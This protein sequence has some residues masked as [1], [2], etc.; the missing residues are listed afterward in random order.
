VLIHNILGLEESDNVYFVEESYASLKNNNLSLQY[1]ENIRKDP[2][3]EV[4]GIKNENG[5]IIG[6]ILLS[7]ETED[8]QEFHA[9]FTNLVSTRPVPNQ[10]C[11]VFSSIAQS[12]KL[13]KLQNTTSRE[14]SEAVIEYYSLSLVNRKVCENCH[15]KKEPYKMVYIESRNDKLNGILKRYKLK[16]EILEICCGNGMS[17]LPL[18]KMGY[19]PLAI[20]YD[21][22]QICQ[23]LEHNVLD[24]KRTIVLDATRLSEFFPENSFDTIVGFMLGTIYSFNKNIWEKIMG[25]AAWLLKSEGMIILTVNQKEEIEILK[26]ALEKA[27][28]SGN[29]IDNTDDKGIYD[30]W[31]YV[32]TK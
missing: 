2:E 32:G 12:L 13:K 6:L 19:R 9:I 21:R 17:T 22:C 26:S 20:D 15:I 18:H 27:H 3:A 23:G 8:S 30:Q 10:T 14:F 29:L 25:E 4:S 24:P 28:V 1:L 31:V 7:P 11:R 5:E 16:G